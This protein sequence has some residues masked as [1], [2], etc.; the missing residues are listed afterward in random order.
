MGFQ[1]IAVCCMLAMSVAGLCFASDV[2]SRLDKKGNGIVDGRVYYNGKDYGPLG[3]GDTAFRRALGDF[4]AE[5]HP[6]LR[7]GFTAE[8]FN[9]GRFYCFEKSRHSPTESSFDIVQIAAGK[10][11]A[12]SRMPATSS[13]EVMMVDAAESLAD[14]TL[15]PSG[16]PNPVRAYP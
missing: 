13:D 14:K 9:A 8:L 11:R 15:C 4:L 7:Q 2:K 5:T 10:F 12:V 1:K 16:Y 6:S 3:L